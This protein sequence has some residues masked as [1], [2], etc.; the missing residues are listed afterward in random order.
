MTRRSEN[1]RQAL[2]V[3]CLSKNE[4]LDT[5]ETGI[6][7]LLTDLLHMARV[8]GL[9]AFQLSRIAAQH[10]QVEKETALI[11]HER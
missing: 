5:L 11:Q 4:P 6:S 10:F 3:Y 2:N 7:D 8:E 9:D 1:A